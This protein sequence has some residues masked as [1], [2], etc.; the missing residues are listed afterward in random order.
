RMHWQEGG[1]HSGEACARCEVDVGSEATWVKYTQGPIPVTPGGS[2]R[3]TAWVKGEDI[4]GNAGWYVHVDGEQPQVVNMHQAWDGTFDWREVSLEFT[5]PENGQIFSCGTLLNGTGTAW[6]DDA[7]FETVGGVGPEVAVGEVER[8]ELERIEPGQPWA[9]GEEWT[10]RTP[11]VARNFGDRER[12]NVLLSVNMHRPRTLLAKH[13]GWRYDLA[14]RIIDPQRDGVLP[15]TWVGGTMMVATD[16]PALSEKV[17]MVYWSPVEKPS[18]ASVRMDLAELGAAGHSP[19]LNASMEEGDDD[20]ADAWPS[21]IEDGNARFTVRRA[22]GGVDGDWCLELDVP[23]E[24]TTVGW[25]GSRQSVAVQPNTRYLLAGHI[26]AEG[27]AGGAR[28]HGHNQKADGTLSDFGPFFSTG[29]TASGDSEWTLTTASFATPPDTAF[30]E[31]HLTMDT[32]GTLRHDGIVLLEGET[33]TVGAIESD[34]GMIDA[35]RALTVWPTNPM[36]KVFADDWPSVAE[37]Q[38][39]VDVFAC[40]NEGEPI[41]I[42]MRA[43]EAGTVT[44]TAGALTGPGGATIAAP[45]IYDVGTVPIDHPMGYASSDQPSYHRLRPTSTGTDG[46]V[47]DWPDPLL[48][49]DGEMAVAANRTQSAWLDFDIPPDA[50]P[51]KYEGEISLAFGDET[52]RLPVTLTVWDYVLPDRKNCQAILDLRSGP[53]RNIFTAPDADRWEMTEAWYRMLAEY[54][55]S[56]GLVEP[57][58]GMTEVDG[59]MAIDYAEFDRACELLFDELN[60]NVAYTPWFFYSFGWAHKARGYFGHDAF[61][62]EWK[63]ILQG[64][65]R[66]FYGHLKERGWEKYFVHYVSDEPDAND[67]EIHAKLAEVCDV[68]REAVPDVLVYSSTWRHLKDLDDSLNLWGVGP[69]A[70]FP[71]DEIEERKTHGD[72]FWFTTDGHMCIDTPYLGIERLLPWFCFKYDVE[73][74]EF[75]GVSWWTYDPWDRGWHWYIRQS[76]DGET[77]RWVRYP[78]GDGYLTYPGDR[79]GRTEPVPTIRLMA[80]REG[81]EDYEIFIELAK[82]A[83]NDPAARAVLDEVKSLVDMPNKGG[84]YSTDIMPNPDAVMAA[85][86]KAGEALGRQ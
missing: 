33:A 18:G 71:V 34:G 81:I 69:H 13:A 8:R 28:I 77:Y 63:E 42:A 85:R 73:A 54:N 64:G 14:V 57:R 72:R 50:A 26:Q 29:T 78:N 52:T 27:L 53:G 59:K 20:T 70:S 5:V 12:E 17:L 19:V 38:G 82:R 15:C 30:L 10:W 79:I 3:L 23:A 49:T 36:V 24:N 62:P 31:I 86:V 35:E 83:E 51:G 75:W 2:Y 60:C 46:W 7:A 4:V 11:I 55:I 21:G 32:T 76:H 43:A 68:S 67:E 58:P 40:R 6:Y 37:P 80:C 47:G 61:T 56:P 9:A 16:L 45:Q 25:V 84:R 1:A 41:Q 39:R 74:Y 65:L 44:V 22:R 48:P 66:D